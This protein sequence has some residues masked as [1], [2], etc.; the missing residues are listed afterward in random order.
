LYSAHPIRSGRFK[1]PERWMVK[2]V[3]DGCWYAVLLACAAYTTTA[4]VGFGLIPTKAKKYSMQS[5]AV[6]NLFL[7][8]IY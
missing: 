2:K 7:R 1:R 3:P 4:G 6:L 8:T 5:A